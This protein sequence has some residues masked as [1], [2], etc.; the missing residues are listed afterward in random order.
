MVDS[1]TLGVKSGDGFYHYTD[2]KKDKTKGDDI[3][4][5]KLAEITDRLI[6]R[7]VNESVACLREG[8]IEITWM[9]ALFLA[10]A[11]R[12]FVVDR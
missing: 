1:G 7:M 8:V 12:P 6:G 3:D 11:L 2:G 9:Q 10:P 4:S 5:S